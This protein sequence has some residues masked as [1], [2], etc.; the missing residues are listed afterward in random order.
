M[1]TKTE[2]NVVHLVRAINA[3]VIP[4]AACVIN[5]CKF[6][7]GELKELD[8]V[9]RGKMR[10]VNILGN[11]EVTRDC[12]SR[13]GHGIKSM[14]H[15]YQETKLRVPCYMA[16]STNDGIKAATWRSKTN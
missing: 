15:V 3:K 7:N 13:G 6:K 14:R 10:A 12:T 5:F 16:F 1:L 2:L 9:L 8:Q 11:K 4:V